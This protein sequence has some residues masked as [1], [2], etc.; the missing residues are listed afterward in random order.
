[1]DIITKE[2]PD[3]FERLELFP[4]NDIHLG[5]A[6]SQEKKFHNFIN[7]IQQ[8]E[9]RYLV[10]IGDLINNNLKTSVGSCYDDTMPPSQQKK[11]MRKMLEPVKDRILCMVSGN[12]EMRTKKEADQDVTE[13][14]AEWLRVPY[15][16][17]KAILKLSFGKKPNGKRQVYI[18]YMVHGWTG[19]R[20]TGRALDNI[21]DL[22]KVVLADVYIAGH[23]HKRA[24][25]KPTFFLPDLYNNKVRQ[26]EQLFAL[27]AGWLDYGGYAAR[28]G[29]RPQVTGSSP[30][31][32]ESRIKQ[33]VAL[34]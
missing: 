34:V 29:M 10:L 9:N 32:L 2:L 23:A 17:D 26:I 11:E 15:S 5:D 4:V 25:E 22:A 1:M 6:L 21:E 24:A 3:H 8:E 20:K 28:G 30:I 12:H 19:G 18:I 7:M 14:I 31:Y 33:A 27:S 13:D 16:E